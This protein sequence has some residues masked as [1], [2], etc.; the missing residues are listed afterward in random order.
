MKEGISPSFIVSIRGVKR[1]KK[2][3][4]SPSCVVLFPPFSWTSKRKGIVSRAGLRIRTGHLS[5]NSFRSKELGRNR[6]LPPLVSFSFLPLF[7]W[8]SKRKGERPPRNVLRL[9]SRRLSANSFR[10]K[11]L[12]RN[13]NL[14]L[15]CVVLFSPFSWTSKRKGSVPPS[16]ARAKR[17]WTP[18]GANGHLPRQNK[19]ARRENSRPAFVVILPF[20]SPVSGRSSSPSR[21]A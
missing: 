8:T 20:S 12:E 4:S 18:T 9:W 5:A 2:S 1:G 14:P 15:P 21:R 11:A 13:R 6:N 16:F 10:G 19:N 17:K 3:K 7:S